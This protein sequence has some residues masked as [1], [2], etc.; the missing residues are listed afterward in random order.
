M[1]DT[2]LVIITNSSLY[3]ISNYA[4]DFQHLH[5]DLSNDNS[6]MP[7]VDLFRQKASKDL[8]EAYIYMNH[9]CY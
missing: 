5:A 8:M 6:A 2:L 1:V 4:I 7:P 9:I 3:S